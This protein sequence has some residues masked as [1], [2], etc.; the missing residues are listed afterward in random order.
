MALAPEEVIVDEWIDTYLKELDIIWNELV[1]V[2]ASFFILDRIMQFPFHLFCP[3]RE[4]P[5]FWQVTFA[6]IVDSVMLSLW[7]ITQ[8]TDGKSLT[9]G[10]WKNGVLKNL[11]TDSRFYA[12]VRSQIRKE[13]SRINQNNVNKR[14]NYLRNK[15]VAHFERD[16]V[17]SVAA[18][19]PKERKVYVHE[20]RM[21]CDDVNSLFHCLCFAK[22]HAIL[23]VDY[24]GLDGEYRYLSDIDRLLDHVANDSGS[25]HA[26]EKFPDNWPDIRQEYSEDDLEA[27]NHYRQRLGLPQV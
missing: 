16:W 7:K 24:M 25:I 4:R 12:Q 1:N 21:L 17:M 19:V 10:R 27:F 15:V 6:S 2:N 14:L 11:K 5:T 8:D 13:V 18:G 20:L 22:G 9:I 26:P 23:P 3:G